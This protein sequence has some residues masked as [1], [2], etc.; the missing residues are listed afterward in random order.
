[1]RSSD[2]QSGKRHGRDVRGGN[3]TLSEAK[4]AVRNQHRQAVADQIWREPQPLPKGPF[5]VIVV[6]PP[7]TYEIGGNSLPYPTLSIDEIKALPV[8]DLAEADCVLWLWTTN[9]HQRVAYDVLD[10]WGFQY[11]NTL[12]WVKDQI[13]T[14]HWLRGQTEHCLLAARG[15]PTFQAPSQGNAI[16]APRRQHSRKLDEFYSLVE[17]TSP[18]SR[19]ELLS[20]EPRKGWSAWGA[21][22]NHFSDD[23]HVD[24]VLEPAA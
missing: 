15:K 19:V 14:G 22:P 23:Q 1:M 24:T 4:V 12:T 16:H 13:G 3:K 20:R 8:P 2:A 11:K 6:D 21:E 18:G 10:A 7:W 9:A 5:R 17:A